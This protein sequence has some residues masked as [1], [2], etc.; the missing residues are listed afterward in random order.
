MNFFSLIDE[1]G[2]EQGHLDAKKQQTDY[3]IKYVVEYVERWLLVS[4]NRPEVTNI[5]FVDCMSNAGIYQD[6]DWYIYIY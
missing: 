2:I 4:V 5:N 3:K 6:G 1:L